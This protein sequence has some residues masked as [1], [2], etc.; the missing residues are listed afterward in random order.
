MRVWLNT[1]LVEASEAHLSAFDHGLTV[2]DGVFETIKV[3]DGATFA[4]TR[5]L[6]RLARSAAMIGLPEP[7]LDLAR[8]AAEEVVA[9]NPFPGLCRLRVTF[10]GG[11]APLGSER[12]EDGPTLLVAVSQQPRPTP[13]V[14]VTTVPWPRNE[15]GALAGVKSTSYAENVVALGYAKQRG[16]GEAI[17]GNVAGHLCEGTGSNIFVVVDG[18]LVT[19]T[20]ESGCLAG[21]TRALVLEWV[22]ATEKDVPLSVL[23]DVDEAFLCGTT[24]DVQPIHAADGRVLPAAPGPITQKAME[25]FAARAAEGIDP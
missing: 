21:V 4:L 17:F 13:T 16:G 22:G 8:R 12:G 10:T 1:G 5:H 7:D 19:P 25:V 9:A 18:E 20:L 15:R 24:R 23:T 2:G 3:T 6:K 14:D 11:V